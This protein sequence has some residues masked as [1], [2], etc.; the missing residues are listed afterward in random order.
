MLTLNVYLKKCTC[1]KII[2]KN[3][4]RKNPQKAKHTPSGYSLCTN[5]SFDATKN[6]LKDGKDCMKRFCKNL[7]EHAMKIID[8]GKKEMILLTY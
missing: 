2:L 5:C 1:A 4:R 8:Y 7:R 6:K 3:L